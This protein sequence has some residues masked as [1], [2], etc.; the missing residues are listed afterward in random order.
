ML[1][2]SSW[3]V[4]AGPHGRA[5]CCCSIGNGARGQLWLSVYTWPAGFGPGEL[6]V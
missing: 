6:S 4:A 3:D 5:T 1:G 2:K